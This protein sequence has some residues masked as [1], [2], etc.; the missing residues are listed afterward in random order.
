MSKDEQT[1]PPKSVI[2]LPGVEQKKPELQVQSLPGTNNIE[3]PKPIN[4]Y[5]QI[6][7]QKPSYRL[8]VLAAF[9]F[10]APF[11]TFSLSDISILDDFFNLAP[12]CCLFF[13]ISIILFSA[14][15]S[16][17]DNW[18]EEI[19][20]ARELIKQTEQIPHPPETQWPLLLGVLFI[21]GGIFWIGANQ[22]VFFIES[23][24]G[25]TF[26]SYYLY[27]AHRR[28]T[29]YDAL[30]EDRINNPKPTFTSEEE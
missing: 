28:T 22:G 4:N 5:L 10:I 8:S 9:F 15:R 21:F 2:I 29:I 3:P 6:R 16:Q 1:M 11:I 24:L 19:K 25:L 30:I 20:K 7:S 27:L 23:I 26:I 14:N 13:L 12:I 18:R 17:Y